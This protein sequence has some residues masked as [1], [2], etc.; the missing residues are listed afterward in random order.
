MVFDIKKIARPNILTLEPYRCAR[1][2][3]SEGVLLDANENTFGPS[4]AESEIS[5]EEKDL[6]LN[7][8][9][10]PHQ[11]K[12]KSQIIAYRNGQSLKEDAQIKFKKGLELTTDNLCLGVGS[13]ESIDSLIRCCVAP[14]KEKMVVCP[15]TYG[16]YAICS[17]VNEAGLVQ[18]PL[19]LTTFQI[20]PDK[21]W[22]K[23]QADPAIKL[24]Y[25]TSPGN[26]TATLIKQ[27]L[28]LQLLDKVETSSWNGLIVV[29]EAYIDFSP[30]GASMC[31]LV[32]EH[33]NLVV[34]QTFSKAFGLAGIRLGVTYS[35]KEVSLLL[36]SMKYPYNISNI[37][38]D[39][40]LRATSKQ[41]IALKEKVCGEIIS[42]RGIVLEKILKL[43]GVGANVGGV[44][45][46]FILI[47][48]LNK[49]GVPDNKIAHEVYHRLATE[50]QVVTRFRGNELGCTGCLRITIGTPAENA[51]FLWEFENVLNNVRENS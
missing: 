29:D 33:K 17:T 43:N 30:P 47:S 31:V 12:L 45:S 9:P 21:I 46:N 15:P 7:R 41:S 8:Y 14:T 40:A 37:T 51:K 39:V 11:Q 44:D 48:L 3:F 26:P 24:V 38:S 5:A 25:I 4:L 18:V 6:D 19:D 2:D 22:A 49:D 36:N 50:R 34:M 28:I 23:L 10:D 42:Q 35:T 13:D 1:D 27:E 32:N 20:Q 16:M